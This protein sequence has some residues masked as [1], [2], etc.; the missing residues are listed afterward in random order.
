[1][2][3]INQLNATTEYFWLQTDPEDILNKASA[4]LWKLMGNAVKIGNW[5]IKPSEIV[6]GGKM[7]KVPLK[8]NISNRGAYGADTVINQSKKDLIEAARFRWAGAVGSN[9]LNLDDLTQNTG[10]AEIIDLTKTGPDTARAGENITYHFRVKNLGDVVQRGGTRERPRPDR[11][12][13]P[14]GVGQTATARRRLARGDLPPAG[15]ANA[16]APSRVVQPRLPVGQRQLHQQARNAPQ[17]PPPPPPTRPPAKE[18]GH[19]KW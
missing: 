8:Y 18:E 7:V 10:D 19:L 14:G 9:T 5:E 17:P 6:D 1:M 12:A 3:L 11:P 2:S 4:L 15:R 13:R 16:D